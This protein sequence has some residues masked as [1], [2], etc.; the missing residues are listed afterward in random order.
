MRYPA[1]A[2]MFYPGSEKDLTRE[3]KSCFKKG[4]GRM[5]REESKKV[6][7]LVSPHAGYTYSGPTAAYG[8]LAMADGG[9]PETVIVLGPNHH[10]L[11]EPIGVSFDDFATPIGVMRNDRELAEAMDI[12]PDELSHVSEHSMEVQLPFV[13]FFDKGIR[14]VCISMMDQSLQT[15]RWLGD[16]ISRAIRMTGRD[17]LIVASSDFTHCGRNYGYPVPGGMNAGEFAR[18]RDLPVIEKLLKFDLE[19]AHAEKRRLGT[20]AC[21]VGPISAMYEAAKYLGAKEAR[22][23]NYSTSYDVSPSSSAVGY[24][25]MALY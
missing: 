19:G 21:G 25:S 3:L 16:R 2:G 6:I 17:T 9:L 20:T 10:G 8:F 13:Q 15:A 5:D 7:G 24:A 11:G 1:V 18:S 22:L 14:Q 12:P 4:P 23:L